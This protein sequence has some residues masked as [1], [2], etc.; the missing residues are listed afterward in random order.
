LI[1]LSY[2]IGLLSAPFA[3]AVRG[4]KTDGEVPRGEKL[5]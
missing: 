3:V 5:L 2:E 4:G 1:M